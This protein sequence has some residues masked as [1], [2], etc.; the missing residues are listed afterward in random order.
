MDTFGNGFRISNDIIAMSNNISAMQYY[1][2]Q[3]EFRLI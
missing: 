3:Y 2:V 1:N